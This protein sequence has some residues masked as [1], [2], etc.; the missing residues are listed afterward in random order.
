MEESQL[1][2]ENQVNKEPQVEEETSNPEVGFP[3]SQSKTKKKTNILVFIILGIVILVGGIIF[4]VTK[5]NKESELVSPSPTSEG[6]IINTPSATETPEPV[7]KVD[8]SIEV[9]NG[10]GISGEAGY[11]Q[12]KLRD[13]GYTDIEVGNADDQDQTVTTVTF[14]AE[15]DEANK[16]EIQAELEKLYEDVTVKTS[17]SISVDASI[18]TGL[19][20]GQTPKPSATATPKATATPTATATST[21]TPTPIGTGTSL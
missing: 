20:K 19:K 15:L 21:A 16:N 10:T 8:V 18:V 7:D 13:L 17:S 6:V 9:L 4:F 11:L 14:S 2:T 1:N 3:L 5:G 12:G